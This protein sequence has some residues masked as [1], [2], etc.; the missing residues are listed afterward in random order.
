MGELIFKVSGIALIAAMAALLLKK[1]GADFAL[2]IKIGAGVLLATLCLQ[3]ATPIV[4]Y[5]EEACNVT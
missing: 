4:A 3:S 1:W 2:L 5:L